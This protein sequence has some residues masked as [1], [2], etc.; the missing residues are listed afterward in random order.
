MTSAF[1][2]IGR[3]SPRVL[4]AVQR[5]LSHCYDW[6]ILALNA[7]AGK[8]R[9]VAASVQVL[10]WCFRGTTLNGG[11]TLE[12]A[13]KETRVLLGRIA[14]GADPAEERRVDLE[15]MTVKELCERYLEDAR[16]GMIL[17]NGRRPKKPS[18]IYT[19]DGRIKRHIVSLL[20]T[21]EGEGHQLGRRH[22]LHA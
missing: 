9:Q 13:R 6:V 20:G 2:A 12:T 1:G 7:A 8:L 19:D 15:A 4:F 11:A 22:P 14:Q 21:A 5:A 3:S 16:K 10:P 18:T 17:G